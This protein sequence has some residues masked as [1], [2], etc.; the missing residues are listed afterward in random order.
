MAASMAI[1]VRLGRTRL[2]EAG[3]LAE[4]RQRVIF[5]EDRDHRAVLAGFPDHG[6]RNAGDAPRHTEA[7]RLQRRHMLGA[8]TR[9]RIAELRHAPD[10]IA[11]GDEAL[12]LGIDE[13]PDLFG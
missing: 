13:T 11:Q 12:L 5:A 8:G 6:R 7:L 4:A 9:L 10:A 1:A 2:G 3:D